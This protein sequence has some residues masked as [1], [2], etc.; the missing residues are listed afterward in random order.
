M[1]TRNTTS[2]FVQG[3]RANPPSN[4]LGAPVVVFDNEDGNGQGGDD[5]A[6]KAAKAEADKTA[7]ADKAA[8]DKAAADKIA[9]DAAAKEKNKGLTVDELVAQLEAERKEKAD[10]VAETMKRKERNRTLEAEIE[11]YK[12]IDPDEA[13]K[14]AQEKV[15]A[16]KKE[17]EKRGEFDRLVEM[18][19]AEHDKEKGTIV[20][21]FEET[22]SKLSAA[23]NQIIELTIGQAF[24]TSAFI[25]DNLTLTPTKARQLYADHFAIEDG[26]LIGYDKPKSSS[27]RTKLVNGSGQP[28]PF[29]AAMQRLIDADPE[30]NS[31]LRSKAAPGAGS[32]TSQDAGKT[33]QEDGTTELKGSARIAKALAARASA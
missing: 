6:A 8:A 12:G 27:E 7:A 5:E 20:Q 24:A 4:Y 14:L 22:K 16:E 10:L 1:T 31:L 9:A 13:R 26:V 3:V 32:K 2:G 25:K 29:D 28:V 17:L 19:R 11:K 21:E 23:Q 15:D 18:M 30:K 33:K